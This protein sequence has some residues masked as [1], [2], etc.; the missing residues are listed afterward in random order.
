M[1]YILFGDQARTHLLPFTYIRPLA[2]IRIGMLTIR[3]KWEWHLQAKTSSLTVDYLSKK[4]PLVREADNVLINSSVF[5]SAG[6]IAE[7]LQLTP[8][9]TLVSPAP[10]SSSEDILIAHRLQAED[11]DNLDADLIDS[12]EPMETAQNI[13][14]VS[15]LWDIVSMNREEL[16]HDFAILTKGRQG[17]P[18][19]AHV[20][21]TAP[22]NIF[23]EEG[24]VIEHAIIN[25]SE[26]VVYIGRD[27]HIMDGAMLRGPLAIGEGTVIRMSSKLYGNTSIGPHCKIGGEITDSVI[28]GYA[29]KAHD[30]FLGHSVVG[31]WCNLGADTNVSNLK[32]NMDTVRLWDYEE[33]SFVQTNLQHCGAYIGD[34]TKCGINTMFNSGT[35]IGISAQ[36]FGTGFMRNFIPSFTWGSVAGVDTVRI[37][38]AIKTAEMVCARRNVV[39]TDEDAAI[40][41][42]VSEQTTALRRL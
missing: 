14:K 19:P 13:R 42:H 32:I 9:Q 16:A 34:F 17:M 11:I 25:A 40:L 26:G 30:G 28:F 21:T 1:N 8:N 38:K 29:N 31:E 7:I 35:V 41:R 18:I 4:Y 22:E 36:I 5:P 2:D 15:H 27:A 33:E 10:D 12:V 39:F 24:A 23:I 3:E 6:L 20:R 37:E